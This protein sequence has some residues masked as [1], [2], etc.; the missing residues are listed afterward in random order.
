MII[1]MSKKNTESIS[2]MKYRKIVLNRCGTLDIKFKN[3]G[4]SFCDN[5]SE[6]NIIYKNLPPEQ[7]NTS[8]SELPIRCRALRRY[9]HMFIQ[10]ANHPLVEKGIAYWSDDKTLITGYT[11]KN[12]PKIYRPIFQIDKEYLKVQLRNDIKLFMKF[13]VA[14]K[15]QSIYKKIIINAP[16]FKNL[17]IELIDK[18]AQLTYDPY[19]LT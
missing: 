14:D 1:I 12:N 15:R 16:Y 7:H 17:P 2:V 6:W 10:D 13:I 9:P 3:T 11:L 18:I 5:D 8:L 19:L 4:I